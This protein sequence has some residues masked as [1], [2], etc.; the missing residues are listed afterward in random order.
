M[1]LKAARRALGAGMPL[2]ASLISQLS[3]AQT[4]V[5]QKQR[6][7]AS[8][9]PPAKPKPAQS[10][11]SSNSSSLPNATAPVPAVHLF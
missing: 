11:S 9:Q 6:A 5:P 4:P 3:P 8:Q 10:P 1:M 7:L 2:V